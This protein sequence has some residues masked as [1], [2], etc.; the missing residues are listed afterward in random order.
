MHFRLHDGEGTHSITLEFG[1]LVIAGMTGRDVKAVQADIDEP[2]EIGVPGPSSIPAIGDITGADRFAMA[3]VDP[4]NG[5]S[6][7]HDYDTSVLPLV[8]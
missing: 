8:S 4:G 6:L 7:W 2:A 1:E 3:L 5:R